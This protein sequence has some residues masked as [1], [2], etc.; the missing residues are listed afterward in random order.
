MSSPCAVRYV[1][2][3]PASASSRKPALPTGS[4]PTHYAHSTASLAKAGEDSIASPARWKPDQGVYSSAAYGRQTRSKNPG[5]RGGYGWDDDGDGGGRC[6][7]DSEGDDDVVWLCAKTK[8][9][10]GKIDI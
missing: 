3:E 2:P 5:E 4:Q 6:G 10:R 1:P 8:W 7:A 9:R